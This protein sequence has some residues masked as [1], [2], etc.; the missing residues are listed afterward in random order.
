MRF[1]TWKLYA[2]FSRCLFW[3]NHLCLFVCLF[4]FSNQIL[5]RV[6]TKT[7]PRTTECSKP[8][9][10]ICFPSGV[11]SPLDHALAH[12][13]QLKICS[14]ENSPPAHHIKT[15]KLAD[16]IQAQV[17]RI[18]Y[19]WMWRCHLLVTRTCLLSSLFHVWLPGAGPHALTEHGYLALTKASVQGKALYLPHMV[20]PASH[21][22][23]EIKPHAVH[24]TGVD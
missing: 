12:G 18:P 6:R 16:F 8:R 14:K 7:R 17:M 13:K 23:E 2:N 19:S 20:C 1:M 22:P 5:Q 15:L 11:T 3:S 21:F 24:F 9:S 4:V 10:Q